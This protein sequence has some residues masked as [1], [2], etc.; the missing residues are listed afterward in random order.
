MTDTER[1]AELDARLDIINAERA[2]LR[3]EKEVLL[4]ERGK[5]ATDQHRKVMRKRKLAYIHRNST[6][7]GY[8]YGTKVRLMQHTRKS[9]RF[10]AGAWVARK[11]DEGNSRKWIWFGYSNLA[12]KEPGS[13]ALNRTMASMFS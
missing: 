7:K 2:T 3:E 6:R 8:L 4:K 11:A 10:P 13:I 5:I 12:I 1:L 9:S